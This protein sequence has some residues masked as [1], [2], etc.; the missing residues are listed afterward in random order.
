MTGSADVYQEFGGD[1]FDATFPPKEPSRAKTAT[2]ICTPYHAQYGPP[3]LR[4]EISPASQPRL[5]R[6]KGHSSSRL[7]D[8]EGS[9]GAW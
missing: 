2:P 6:K 4:F 7:A 9:N 8:I 3:M 1:H 5:E